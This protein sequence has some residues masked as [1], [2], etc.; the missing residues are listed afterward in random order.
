M[1]KVQMYTKVLSDAHMGNATTYTF[2]YLKSFLLSELKKTALAVGDV[3]V[4]GSETTSYGVSHV[5]PLNSDKS[6]D[7]DR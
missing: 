1:T 7:H 6:A 5:L 2:P 3:L 4:L